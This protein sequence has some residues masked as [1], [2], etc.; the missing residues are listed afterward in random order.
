M[1][2]GKST[3]ARALLKALGI[4]QP[5]EGSPTFALVHEYDSP[6][7]RVAHLDVYRLSRESEL[8]SSGIQAL[9]WE[10]DALVISEWLSMFPE[11]ERSVIAGG[12]SW[13]VRLTFSELAPDRRDVEITRLSR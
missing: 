4:H 6:R 13:V 10:R 9:Y 7:G 2:A 1:G 3:F 11:F 12:D 8:E 5:A